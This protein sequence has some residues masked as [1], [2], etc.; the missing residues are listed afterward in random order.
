MDA[1]QF[2]SLPG[3]LIPPVL[4]VVVAEFGHEHAVER[5]DQTLRIRIDVVVGNDCTSAIASSMASL[6][7]SNLVTTL[8][9]RIER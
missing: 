1:Q 9:P 5:G 6:V 8:P 7:S 3:E 2:V 4:A